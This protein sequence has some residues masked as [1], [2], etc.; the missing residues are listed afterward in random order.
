MNTFESMTVT[1]PDLEKGDLI[2]GIAHSSGY[3]DV[4]YS[5]VRTVQGV[6]RE[7]HS[8]HPDGAVRVSYYGDPDVGP[9]FQPVT[10]LHILRPV[11]VIPASEPLVITALQVQPGDILVDRDLE[12]VVKNVNG[13]LPFRDLVTDEDHVHAFRRTDSVR[14]IR[15]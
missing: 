9:L 14:V 1:A 3:S 5:H 8:L 10:Q 6:S 11:R 13:G 7:P 15:T 2:L 4:G 12:T